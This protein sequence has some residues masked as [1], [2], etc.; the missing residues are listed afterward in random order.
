MTPETTARLL[1]TCPDRPG[2]VA[3]V[4]TLLYNHGANVTA[5]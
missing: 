5:L 1:I 2:I 3:A 4:T